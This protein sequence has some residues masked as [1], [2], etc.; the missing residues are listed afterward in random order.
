MLRYCGQE[1]GRS[2]SP[3]LL[4]VGEEESNSGDYSSVSDFGSLQAC[5]ALS[6]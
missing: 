2:L 6:M 3:A 4:P 1:E 5:S